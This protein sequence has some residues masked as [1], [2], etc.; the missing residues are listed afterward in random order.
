MTMSLKRNLKRHFAIPYGCFKLVTSR[1]SFLHSSGWFDSVRKSTPTSAA[2][3]AIPWMNYSVVELIADRLCD[4]FSV[5][6]FGS[7]FSTCFFADRVR[8]VV[9]VEYDRDWYDQVASMVPDNAEVIF[10]VVDGSD[11]YSNTILDQGNRFDVVVV[12][13]KNRNRCLK[14]ATKATSDKGVIILDDSDRPKY[15]PGIAHLVENGYRKL[16]I[17]GIKPDSACRHQ[18]TLFYRD[19]NCFG[20]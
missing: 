6:E 2:G 11:R 15:K 4:S 5:F 14:N 13:G 12:D 8:S 9:S 17:S 7:G 3:D 10:E 16:T 1:R 18:T 19:G 20:L